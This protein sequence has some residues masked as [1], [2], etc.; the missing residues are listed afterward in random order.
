MNPGQITNE[1]DVPW[2]NI[3]LIVIGPLVEKRVEVKEVKTRHPENEILDTSELFRDEAVIDLYASTH[4]ETW[5]IQ[6]NGFDFS[7][8]GVEKSLRSEEHTSEL[9]S[10]S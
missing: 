5:R 4:A 8:L 6:A 10:H 7:C 1:A 2:S 3:A 9:Q